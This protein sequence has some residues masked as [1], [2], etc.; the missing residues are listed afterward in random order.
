[1]HVSVDVRTCG[2][3]KR[4]VFYVEGGTLSVIESYSKEIQ[5]GVAVGRGADEL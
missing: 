3:K 5:I 4:V 1:M 2:F